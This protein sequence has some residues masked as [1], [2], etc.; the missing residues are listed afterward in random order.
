MLRKC[1]IL[2]VVLFI[3]VY[4]KVVYS[5][6]FIVSMR[7]EHIWVVLAKANIVIGNLSKTRMS[8]I[9]C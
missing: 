8:S 5:E 7:K 3:N 1:D 6:K 4:E 2:Y 9:P